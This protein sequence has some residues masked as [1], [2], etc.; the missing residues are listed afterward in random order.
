MYQSNQ[1]LVT[2]LNFQDE[3]CEISGYKDIYLSPT[4]SMPLVV[5]GINSGG[6]DKQAEWMNK[7]M[8]KKIGDISDSTVSHDLIAVSLLQH[9]LTTTEFRKARSPQR[10]SNCRARLNGDAGLQPG[11]VGAL[12]KLDTRKLG[13]YSI[14]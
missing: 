1:D 14:E 10:T 11:Q 12:D 7:L 9:L 4:T 6:D 13:L 3:N 8:G 5:P 2:N